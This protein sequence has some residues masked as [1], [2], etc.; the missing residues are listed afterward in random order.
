MQ[1]CDG[2]CGLAL[3]LWNARLFI[4]DDGTTREFKEPRTPDRSVRKLEYGLVDHL[5]R[6]GTDERGAD[7]PLVAALAA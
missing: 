3:F 4:I 2:E 5:V 1:G 6:E 7:E